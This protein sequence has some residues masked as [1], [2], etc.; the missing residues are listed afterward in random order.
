MAEEMSP[1]PVEIMGP[2]AMH[3]AGAGMLAVR[4]FG[5][6]STASGGRQNEGCYCD[7]LEKRAH[8]TPPCSS[9]VGPRIRLSRIV[10]SRSFWSPA[11]LSLEEYVL[12]AVYSVTLIFRNAQDIY[13]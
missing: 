8:G 7:C 13:C 3:S 12:P 10:A 4:V 1:T 11:T 5:R 6:E 2:F 9:Q